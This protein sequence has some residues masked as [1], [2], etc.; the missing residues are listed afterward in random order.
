MANIFIP[1]P[2][3]V[4]PPMYSTLYLEGI[5]LPIISHP[6]PSL[7]ELMNSDMVLVPEGTVYF[8]DIIPTT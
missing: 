3:P 5:E 1:P 6:L 7:V 4:G 8:A 2:K